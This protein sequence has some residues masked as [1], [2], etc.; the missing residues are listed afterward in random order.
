MGGDISRDGLRRRL[1]RGVS[2]SL[3]KHGACPSVGKHV[4]DDLGE[5]TL[6]AEGEGPQTVVAGQR[7]RHAA[8]VRAEIHIGDIRAEMEPHLP[9][10]G[11][12]LV[13]EH[14]GQGS[15]FYRGLV[16]DSAWPIEHNASE[17]VMRPSSCHHRF[18]RYRPDQPG[19]FLLLG[20]LLVVC[21]LAVAR[22][23]GDREH[24]GHERAKD[25]PEL[26]LCGIQNI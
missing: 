22:A 25:A 24:D 23:V 3:G 7:G 21:L 26:C 10:C 11:F 8:T 9:E 5:S 19:R 12:Q 6:S 13:V 16:F 14:D 20:R 2:R 18:C 4:N 1:R 15:L 17:I